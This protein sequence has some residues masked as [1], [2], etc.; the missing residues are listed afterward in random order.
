MNSVS[1]QCRLEDRTLPGACLGL[2]LLLI[3]IKVIFGLSQHRHLDALDLLIQLVL[4][5][6]LIYLV[7]SGR[8]SLWTIVVVPSGIRMER[9]G[10]V[11]YEG[12][13]G[14]VQIVDEDRAIMTLRSSGGSSFQFPRR[15]VFHKVLSKIG[16]QQQP[17]GEQAG[18]QNP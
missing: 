12:P 7:V 4:A 9:D 1:T 13:S 10:T 6:G 11:L 14:N 17:T 16:V 3:L 18:A 8:S 2:L 15:R 5:A